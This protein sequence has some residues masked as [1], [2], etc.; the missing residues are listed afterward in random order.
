M[1]ESLGVSAGQWQIYRGLLMEEP[2]P[3]SLPSADVEALLDAGLIVPSPDAAHGYRAV[4]PTVSIAALVRE[5]E[6]HLAAQRRAHT[7]LQ[8]AVSVFTDEYLTYRL[9]RDLESLEILSDGVAVA[10]RINELID[11]AKHEASSLV[12]NPMNAEM[13]QAAKTGDENMLQRGLRVRSIYTDPV[14]HNAD[15]MEYLTWFASRGAQLRCLPSLPVRMVLID[16]RVA[17]IAS[18]PTTPRAGAAVIRVPGLITALDTLFESLWETAAPLGESTDRDTLPHLEAE[19]L[20]GM[21]AGAKDDTLAHQLGVSVRTVRRLITKLYDRTGANSRFQMAV[22]AL[23][24]GWI[25]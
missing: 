5:R 1:L 9:H 4:S 8:D 15:S 7:A 13:L 6:Q 17:V 18:D 11:S 23:R 25:N 20:R 22:Y 16:R 3:A 12:T 24:R 19:I 14:Q 21:A 10:M 2:L